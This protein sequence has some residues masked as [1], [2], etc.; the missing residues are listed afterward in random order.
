MAMS[1]AKGILE[2]IRVG[3]SDSDCVDEL[4]SSTTLPFCFPTC[5]FTTPPWPSSLL[6][7]MGNLNFIPITQAFPPDLLLCFI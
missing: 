7:Q 2:S 3:D 6:S 5:F 4:Q 1:R